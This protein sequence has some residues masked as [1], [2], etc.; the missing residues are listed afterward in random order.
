MKFVWK[1][2]ENHTKLNMHKLINKVN[3]SIRK[4]NVLLHSTIINACTN[5]PVRHFVEKHPAS[6]LL[7]SGQNKDDNDFRPP[8]CSLVTKITTTKE[9][10]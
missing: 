9:T 8:R 6:G 5:G 4:P 3:E 10:R 1:K 2:A 7:C